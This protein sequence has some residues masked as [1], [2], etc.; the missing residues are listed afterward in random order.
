[1]VTMRYLSKSLALAAGL[2]LSASAFGAVVDALDVVQPTTTGDVELVGPRTTLIVDL[3]NG[4]QAAN[5]ITDDEQVNRAALIGLDEN[6]DVIPGVFHDV[7]AGV[8]Q[9]AYDDN[10]GVQDLIIDLSQVVGVD[11][12]LQTAGVAS[13][14]LVVTTSDITLNVNNINGV[15][16]AFD[17]ND[18][19]NDECLDVD[20][21]QPRLVQVIINDAGTQAFFVFSEGLNT[22]DN[23]N[24]DNHTVLA[25]IDGADFQVSTDNGASFPDTATLLSNPMFVGSG[26]S[27]IRFDRAGAS[28]VVAGSSFIRP[29]YSGATPPAVMHDIRDYVKNEATSESAQVTTQVALAVTDATFLKAVPIGG[30][31]AG[32]L[33]VTFNNPVTDPGSA[34]AY[35]LRRAAA[36]G[37]GQEDS[38]ITLSN[39]TVDPDD[40]FSVLLDVTAGAEEG[41]GPDGNTVS[42]DLDTAPQGAPLTVRVDATSGTTDPEDVF[43]GVFTGTTDL[44]I[45]DSI[46]PVLLSVAFGDVDGDGHQD[47]VYFVFNEPMG[48]V[49]STSGIKVVRNGGV[50]VHPFQ[51]IDPD[52]GALTEAETVADGTPANNELPGLSVSR[53]SIP[54]GSIE[55][56]RDT[57]NAI[58]VSYDALSFDWDNDGDAGLAND[59][60]EA[61][62]STGDAGAVQAQ[63]VVD[64]GTFADAAGNVFTNGGADVAMNATDDRANPVLAVA[65][66][67]AGDNQDQ[68]ASNRQLFTESDGSLGQN[69]SL[70]RLALCFSE[71]LAFLNDAIVQDSQVTFDGNPFASGDFLFADNN[72][73]TFRAD[74]ADNPDALTPGAEIAILSASGIED[75]AG[76]EAT[77]SGVEAQDATAPYLALVS[78]VDPGSPIFPAFLADSDNDGFVNQIRINMNQPILPSSVTMDSFSISPGTIT[79]IEVDDNNPRVIIIEVQDGVVSM[80]NMVQVTYRGGSISTQVE[81]D[82]DEGGTGVA[83]AAVN[84]GFTAQSVPV[85]Q[86]PTQGVAIMDVIGTITDGA[87]PLPAGTKVYAMIAA[88]VVRRVDATHNNNFFSISEWEDSDSTAAWTNWLWGFP[89]ARTV[90]LGRDL[91][92]EQFYSNYKW[93][94]YTDDGISTYKDVIS[95]TINARSLTQITFTGRGETNLDNVTGGTVQL[96]WDVIRSDDGTVEALYNYGHYPFGPPVTSRTVVTGDDGRFEL[97]ISAP[98]SAF[99]GQNFLNSVDRPVILIVERTDGKRFV[100][101]SLLTSVNGGPLLFRPMNRTQNSDRTAVDATVFNINL[102][103]V[104]MEV[105]HPGWNLEGFSRNSGWST[106]SSTR[107]VLP[108]GV[109]TANVVT[110]TTLPFVG[111]LEQ[112]VFWFEDDLDG[113]WLSTEDT[114]FRDIVIDSKR[115]PHFAFTMTSLGVQIGSGMNNLV[116]GYGFAMFIYDSG[117][118]GYFQ[119]G[120]PLTGSAIFA[121][122]TTFPNSSATSGWGIFTARQDFDPASGIAS[123]NSNLDYI[124]LFRNNGNNPPAGRTRF[125][126]SSMDLAAPAGSDNINDATMIDAGQAFFG[127]YR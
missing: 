1:M 105:L 57:N 52:T 46:E 106:A 115:F 25:D 30:A 113:M 77:A 109:T 103:N 89:W 125:E 87:T 58:C 8:V 64:T 102:A 6:G 43:G 91:E 78:P 29:A 15:Q 114:S 107:P 100:V 14:R 126:V 108:A 27:I 86:M 92:N 31:E 97:H 111:P 18:E 19:A 68:D 32:A 83:V 34:D 76:N 73:L 99:T 37:S 74:D 55:E 20:R 50:T 94:G 40:P 71:D 51:L 93:L 121:S 61:I 123:G 47:A 41:V 127:H 84:V 82:P 16:T 124:I 44:N 23:D 60:D 56:G 2:A 42:S 38:T 33:R 75:V 116:G 104:G 53:T 13:F 26:N 112:F 17:A 10:N 118:I 85:S 4:L 70:R 96:G 49:T 110:G 88:P 117:P 81:S 11:S 122:G 63:Y 80:N 35:L 9:Q 66:F 39:P 45:E 24:D 36:S 90:Y 48:N 120:A 67:Y 95:L 72:C 62:P 28:N 98:I 119:F 79:S 7:S 65:L 21:T 3:E 54:H 12:F 101:S 22:G 59:A 5:T 69:N